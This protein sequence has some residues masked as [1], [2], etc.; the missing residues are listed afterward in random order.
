MDYTK[1]EERIV[2]DAYD[3]HHLIKWDVLTDDNKNLLCMHGMSLKK[4]FVGIAFEQLRDFM[5]ECEQE[6]CSESALISIS[7]Y[8]EEVLQEC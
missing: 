5:V 4:T 8:I 3:K 2:K 7:E 1:S 6:S